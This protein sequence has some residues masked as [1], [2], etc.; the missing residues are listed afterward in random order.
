MRLGIGRPLAEA[1]SV[2]SAQRCVDHRLIEI[3]LCSAILRYQ[4][5]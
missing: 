1:R 4:T 2:E 5:L 3:S